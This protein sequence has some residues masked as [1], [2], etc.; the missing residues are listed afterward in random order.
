M[1][2]RESNLAELSK[3]IFVSGK[4][5][6][7]VNDLHPKLKAWIRIILGCVHHRKFTNSY[8]YI[9]VDQQYILYYITTEKKVNL[10][11]LLFKHL[12]DNVKDTR[13][14]SKKMKNYI[15]LCRL[16]LDILME[17]KLINSLTYDQ[18]SKGMQPLTGR[19]FNAKG[20]KNMGIIIEVISPHTEIPKEV[21]HNRMILWNILLSSQ[22]HIL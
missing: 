21:I 8:D 5:S 18:F 10:L 15:P 12:R 16:V 7:K 14:G 22:S 9:N 6:S 3:V 20:M 11:A 13:D 2:E 4:H 17:S 1:V 19:M